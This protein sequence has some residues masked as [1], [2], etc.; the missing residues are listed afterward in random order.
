MATAFS[1]RAKLGVEA[2]R[3]MSTVFGDAACTMPFSSKYASSSAVWDVQY[4]TTMPALATSAVRVQPAASRRSRTTSPTASFPINA[5]RLSIR[6][7]PFRA[8]FLECVPRASAAP[9]P[10]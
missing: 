7:A 8:S 2:D 4:V 10:A 1:S 9:I 5:Y 3:S 6:A